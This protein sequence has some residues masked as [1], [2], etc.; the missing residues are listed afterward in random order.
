MGGLKDY[1]EELKKQ[2]LDEEKK[3][4]IYEKVL[5]RQYSQNFLYKAKFYIKVAA[6]TFIILVVIL[7]FFP[8]LFY[9]A[10]PTLQIKTIS[11]ITG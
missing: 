6:Y 2:Q 11:Y 7:S 3:I 8:F 4:E 5:A 9:K 10:E 1:F